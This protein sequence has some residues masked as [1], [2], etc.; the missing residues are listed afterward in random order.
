MGAEQVIHGGR[1]EVPCRDGFDVVIEAV[2][3]ANTLT[4]ALRL[5]ARGGKV[6]VLGMSQ[7]EIPVDMFDL[8]GREIRL[9]GS[10]NYDFRIPPDCGHA[11]DRFG[12]P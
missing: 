11:S 1:D 6:V 5:A 8:V 12:S 3:I 4:Q 9:E 10:F 2:G 7:Q